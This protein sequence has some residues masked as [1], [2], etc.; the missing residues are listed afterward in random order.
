MNDP[1]DPHTEDQLRRALG[2]R[3]QETTASPDALDQIRNRRPTNAWSR[4]AVYAGVAA[5]LALLVGIAVWNLPNDDADPADVAED[6]VPTTTVVIP[7]TTLGSG[8]PEEPEEPTT[9]PSRPPT[10]EAG[11]VSIERFVDRNLPASPAEYVSASAVL[12]PTVGPGVESGREAALGW[13]GDAFG[14]AKESLRLTG[15]KLDQVALPLG[16]DTNEVEIFGLRGVGEDGQPSDFTVSYIVS[17][18]SD[19]GQTWFVTHVESQSFAVTLVEMNTADTIRITGNGRAFEGT[20]SIR[21]GEADPVL[22]NVGG[23]ELDGFSVI[24]PAPAAYPAPIVVEG[25]IA[26]ES[27]IPQIHAFS[28]TPVERDTDI[29]VFGVADDDVLNVRSGAGVG[30]DIV[31]ALDPDA[32]GIAQTGREVL[33]GTDTWWEVTDGTVTGWVNRRFL[34]VQH[35]SRSVEN[36][37]LTGNPVRLLVEENPGE[38][39]MTYAPTVWIG[40]IGVYADA[41]TAWT[42]IDRGELGTGTFDFCPEGLDRFREDCELT[43]ADFL[44][45]ETAKWELSMW[46]TT[47]QLDA[48]NLVFQTGLTAEFYDRFTTSTIF[49]PEPD[50]ETSLDWRRYTIVWGFDDGTPRVEG[51]WRWGWTP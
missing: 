6:P 19:G 21:V 20:A 7:T 8:V 36:L 33:V 38:N 14:W 48:E 13:A 24:V 25:G 44:G 27:E 31:G 1:I 41:P 39:T 23:F 29:V 34:S 16:W 35:S 11:R 3:A 51:M 30:N 4:P 28:A 22:I 40:G 17:A 46:D 43:V 5:V 47:P 49:I 12:W 26:L 2:E 37:D 45:V 9:T 18:S 10:P 15:L 42:A 50:P 32:T